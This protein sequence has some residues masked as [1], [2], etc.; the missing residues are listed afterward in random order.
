MTTLFRNDQISISELPR[1]ETLEMVQLDKKY[2]TVRAIGSLIFAISSLI[3]L[4]VFLTFK[5]S[6]GNTTYVLVGL[7]AWILLI[8]INVFLVVK[9]FKV[10]AYAI[11]DKDIMYRSGLIWRSET[12]I[13]FNRVQHV[14]INRGPLDRLFDLAK[15]NIYTAGGQSS[16]LS[17]PGLDP[18]DAKALKDFILKKTLLDEEE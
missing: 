18:E 4:S 12:S 7:A 1:I 15:I 6:W 14:D 3:A 2:L 5:L 13:P 10:K 8:L 16:D 11:R 9:G 17:I